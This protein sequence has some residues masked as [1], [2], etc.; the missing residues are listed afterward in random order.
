MARRRN[1]AAERGVS[2]TH[3]RSEERYFK[4]EGS[5]VST[6]AL[7]EWPDIGAL[8]RLLQSL[9]MLDAILEPEWEYRYYSFN[10]RW[11]PGQE[12]GSM[13]NGSGDHWFALFLPAGA[14]IVGLAHE[15]PMYRHG[16]PWPGMFVGLPS[17]LAEVQTE[18]A[19]EATH[20]T[21]C[22]WRLATDRTWSRGQVEFSSDLDADGSEHLLHLL[23]GQPHSYATFAADYFEMD[24]PTDAV[25]SVYAHAPLTRDLVMRLNP[26]S[27]PADLEPD[28]QEIG[29]PREAG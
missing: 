20:C 22:V 2:Q 19:F 7:G 9:A 17:E 29:Y 26:R 1:L 6:R 3:E 14:G 16:D 8:R 15:A 24:V 25:A 27:S 18:P 5:L 10:S 13:R 4:T 12:M 21:F 28:L 23:D 11:A